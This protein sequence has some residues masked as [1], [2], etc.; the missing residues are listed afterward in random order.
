M[1]GDKDFQGIYVAL[2]TPMTP[3]SELNEDALRQ[4][5]DFNIDSGVD[6]FW[7]AGGGGESVL[8]DDDENRRIAEIS[9]E[10]V[11][12]RAKIIMHVGAPTTKRSAA[13]AKH[14]SNVGVDAICCVPPFVIRVI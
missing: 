1:G 2:A 7:V 9:A 11:A 5:L 3:E 12:G 8:L 14:A 4:L 10:Q 6:G 13:M